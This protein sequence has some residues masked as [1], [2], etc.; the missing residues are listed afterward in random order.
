M[1]VRQLLV[2]FSNELKYESKRV[3][4]RMSVFRNLSSSR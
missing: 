3:R 2:S 1:W 4:K